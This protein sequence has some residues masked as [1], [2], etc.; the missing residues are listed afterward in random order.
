MFDICPF[1]PYSTFSLSATLFFRTQQISWRKSLYLES[2][3]RK[4]AGHQ[5]EDSSPHR[6]EW[7]DCWP[8][9][10]WTWQE[11]ALMSAMCGT[12]WTGSPV[13]TGRFCQLISVESLW[14]C[15]EKRNTFRQ[16][17]EN[18]KMMRVSP[19]TVVA[20]WGGIWG[21]KKGDVGS[22][23]WSKNGPP[24]WA[25]HG[26]YGK[27]TRIIKNPN[28]PNVWINDVGE[29]LGGLDSGT[30]P[31]IWWPLDDW[32]RPKRLQLLMKWR[33]FFRAWWDWWHPEEEPRNNGIV[34]LVWVE[35]TRISKCRFRSS[36]WF[37]QYTWWRSNS[38]FT[39]ELLPVGLK[40]RRPPIMASP[41]IAGITILD[42]LTGFL[43]GGSFDFGCQII[44]RLGMR[45]F[46]SRPVETLFLW[47]N[48]WYEW[49]NRR[50]IISCHAN[51]IIPYHV[52]SHHLNP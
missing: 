21:M 15:A 10:W 28:F 13:A 46:V 24:E 4:G 20:V 34:K 31:R 12:K 19:V 52:V 43:L 14:P 11:A 1:S 36:N 3:P 23:D 35:K 48:E 51:H 26:S 40:P 37:K 39:S 30:K 6:R 18:R 44:Q 25:G 2:A 33:H 5:R 22:T 45:H 49:R 17:K 7:F 38:P 16:P 27:M 50:C 29:I 32:S 41:I 8:S 47:K 42:R 9:N